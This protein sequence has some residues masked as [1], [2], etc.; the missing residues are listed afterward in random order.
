MWNA[1]DPIFKGFFIVHRNFSVNIVN[2]GPMLRLVKISALEFQNA[3][4]T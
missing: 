2:M 3:L 1:D 4:R